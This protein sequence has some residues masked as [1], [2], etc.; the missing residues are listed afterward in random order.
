MQAL[1]DEIR[2]VSE[3]LNGMIQVSENGTTTIRMPLNST[4]GT[5][6]SLLPPPTATATGATGAR[7]RARAKVGAGEEG[8]GKTRVR[9]R[10]DFEEALGK[11]SG[12]GGGVNG[13]GGSE[14]DRFMAQLEEALVGYETEGNE[15]PAT[16]S[17]QLIAEYFDAPSRSTGPAISRSGA[18]RFQNEVLKGVMTVSSV[19]L[20]Q[21]AVIFESGKIRDTNKLALELEQRYTS[22]GLSEEVDYLLVMNERIPNLNQSPTQLALESMV[23]ASP[24]IIVFP[25]SWNTTVTAVVTDPVKKFWRQTVSSVAVATTLIYAAARVGTFDPTGEFMT[26][27]E[28]LQVSEYLLPMALSSAL[29]QNAASFAEFWVAKAKGVQINSVFMPSVGELLFSFGQRSTYL[30]PPKNRSDMFDIAFAGV[31]TAL[32]LSLAA[33]YA[34]MALGAGAEREV[35]AGFPTIPMSLLQVNTFVS[36]LFLAQFGDLYQA[37]S[38]MAQATADVPAQLHWLTVVGITSFIANTLQLVPGDNSAGSK[39]SYA[40]LGREYGGLVS[41]LAGVFKSIFFGLMIFNVG[42][43]TNSPLLTK[44]KVLLDYFIVSQLVNNEFEVQLAKDNLTSVSDG[45]KSLYYLLLGLL[46]LSFFP[47]QAFVSGV[48][49]ELLGG[50]EFLKGLI[51][52]GGVQQTTF[53]P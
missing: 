39:L 1:S 51:S 12:A 53:L 7:A 48:S 35:A 46:L 30:S 38:D 11:G 24:A 20:S 50:V 13:T 52:R 36:Q 31:A 29:I 14:I 45:R 16:T 6:P 34:G 37:G 5:L 27:S 21:G 4:L 43:F 23:G 15:E 32:G 17:E 44:P 18:G 47:Y 26:S 40:T 22:S 33:V 28:V 8:K 10:L 49:E 42:G 41:A 25:K 19:K 3:T 2:A 9:V